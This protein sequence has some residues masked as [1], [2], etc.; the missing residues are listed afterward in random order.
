MSYVHVLQN[1]SLVFYCLHFIKNG[2]FKV[3]SD[4]PTELVGL[5]ILPTISCIFSITLLV[6][7]KQNYFFKFRCVHFI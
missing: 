1:I 6:S 7:L 3:F 2:Y 4:N 5:F